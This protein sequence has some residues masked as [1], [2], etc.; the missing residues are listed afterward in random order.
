ML[1]PRRGGREIDSTYQGGYVVAYLPHMSLYT[2]T[3]DNN[4]IPEKE[5]S[6]PW[7]YLVIV[8][9]IIVR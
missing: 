9:L 4:I 7:F 5:E 1:L 3:Y 6:F 8:A 2:I